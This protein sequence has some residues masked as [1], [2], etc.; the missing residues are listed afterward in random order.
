MTYLP[1]LWTWI[2]I[3]GWATYAGAQA[4]GPIATLDISNSQVS[5]DGYTRDAVLA[6]GVHPG[7]LI[8]GNKGDRFR[9]TV[10]NQLTNLD[11]YRSTS[12]HWHGLHMNRQNFADGAAWVTQCPIS[13]N[14]TFTYDFKAPGQAGTY[15]YHSH[16]ST[17]YCDGLRGPLV[18]YDPR[19]PHKRLYDV[20]D[21]STIITLSDWFHTPSRTSMSPGVLFPI[22]NSTLINGRG[23]Y[24]GGP[25]VPLSIINV[26]R[27][28]RYRFRIIAMACDPF[29]D[30]SI[31]GHNFTV[32]EADGENTSPLLVD[33]F[34]I[35][36]GQRYSVVL[37]A[38]QRVDNY[39]IRA[40]PYERRG[41]EG[42]DN[43]R[44]MAIL[45]YAGAPDA[46]PTTLQDPSVRPLREENLRPL[47][48][49]RAPGRP[50]QGGADVVLNFHQEF[51]RAAWAFRMN[52]ATFVPPTVPV[53]LQIMSGARDAVDLLPSGSVYT[54]PPN[55]VIELS[56]SG[57]VAT[58][59]GPHPFHLHGHTFSVIRSANSTRYNYENPVRRDTIDTG[60]ENDNVTIRFVTDN[61]GPWFLH[62]HIDFHLEMGLAV[63]FAEDTNRT[64][65]ANPLPQAWGNLCPEYE[66]LRPDDRD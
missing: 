66:R 63:V 64:A 22:P 2:L 38:N 47:M 59:G 7:P 53:L 57:T 35:V 15:W 18:I 37:H 13:P 24:P 51:D 54:L 21:E 55:K 39:W 31:D 58:Q 28:R 27:N 14:H 50:R 16:L 30:F 45:R 49:P 42:F 41:N 6:G 4:I 56:I 9:I 65:L 52:G 36:A 26:R 8:R 1:L 32:I 46:D 48:D 19:D 25:A 33:S 5:P 43:G 61:S 34:R 10:R 44:N 17:Q 20:D 3:S 60:L 11:M 23:R 29:W 40:N 12:V 62:C